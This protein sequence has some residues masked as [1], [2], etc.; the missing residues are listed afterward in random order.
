MKIEILSKREKEKIDDFLSETYGTKI[1]RSQ[2]IQPSRERLRIFSGDLSERELMILMNTIRIETI[3]LYFAFVKK[4]DKENEKNQDFR[5]S[6]DSSFIFKEAKKNVLDLNEEQ[7]RT[8]ISGQDVDTSGMKDII[9]EMNSSYP[10]I[11]L[12]YK[13]EI[14]GCGKLTQDKILNFVPKERRIK[15]F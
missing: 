9:Q 6:F 2:F 15:H 8:W 5:L 11:L 3:G 4:T 7:M 10:F 1:P 13:G 14:I 12:R